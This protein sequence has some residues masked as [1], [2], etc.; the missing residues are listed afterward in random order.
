MS[1]YSQFASRVPAGA[2]HSADGYANA[3]AAYFGVDGD[4]GVVQIATFR[5]GRHRVAFATNFSAHQI[6]SPAP[7]TTAVFAPAWR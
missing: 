7:R 4:T 5:V 1:F 2:V 3:A 6:L